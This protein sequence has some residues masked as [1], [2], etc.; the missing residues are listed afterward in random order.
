MRKVK[1]SKVT[2]SSYKT[3]SHG[4]AA[5]SVVTTVNTVLYMRRFLRE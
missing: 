3:G 5:Y 4:D 1:G 2:T